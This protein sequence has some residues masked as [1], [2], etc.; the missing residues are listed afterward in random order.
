MPFICPLKFKQLV[1]SIAANQVEKDPWYG[2]GRDLQCRAGMYCLNNLHN[3]KTGHIILPAQISPNQ[4]YIGSKDSEI[5]P[6]R[7]FTFYNAYTMEKTG[8]AIVTEAARNEDKEV[9]DA[10]WD[11]LKKAGLQTWETV[12]FFVTLDRDLQISELEML[13]SNEV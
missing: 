8:E 9:T 12:P 4:L 6:G 1:K 13:D 3:E 5:V 11:A 7:Q 2:D 10:F